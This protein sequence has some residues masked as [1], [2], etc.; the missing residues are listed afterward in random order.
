MKKEIGEL[1]SIIAMTQ[2]S[3]NIPEG[4]KIKRLESLHATKMKLLDTFNGVIQSLSRNGAKNPPEQTN[5]LGAG[6]SR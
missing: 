1:N 5:Q 3:N 4:D 6:V 2:D